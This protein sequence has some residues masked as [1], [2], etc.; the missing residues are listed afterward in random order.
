MT[1]C[2]LLIY[3]GVARIM[4]DKGFD[5][6]NVEIAA[7]IAE[8]LRRALTEMAALAGELGGAMLSGEVMLY[9]AV[10]MRLHRLAHLERAQLLVESRSRPVRS[11]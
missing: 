9:D 6:S 11:S 2:G 5:L 1:L 10:P 3:R 7:A 4:L 8:H